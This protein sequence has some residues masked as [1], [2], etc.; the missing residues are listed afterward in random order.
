MNT[1]ARR[2]GFTLIEMLSVILLLS[3]LMALLAILLIDVLAV[4]LTQG[5]SQ[6][7]MRAQA[8]LADEYRAD[9]ARAESA[10]QDW[11]KHR[12]D[13]HTLILRVSDTEHIVY[14]W[15]QGRLHRR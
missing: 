13:A 1:P 8:Q 7:R 12:A 15:R 14:Q 3:V 9:V 4:Q 10:P 11:G 6:D 5:A 2:R